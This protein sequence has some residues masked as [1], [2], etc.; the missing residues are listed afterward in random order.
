MRIR[1]TLTEEKENNSKVDKT[2][3]YTRIYSTQKSH[4]KSLTLVKTGASN[5]QTAYTLQ[6]PR[7]TSSALK[8][9]T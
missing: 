1:E 9:S 7:Y 5:L 8:R 6:R 4:S 3:G 2:Y